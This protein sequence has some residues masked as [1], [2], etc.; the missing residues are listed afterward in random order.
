MPWIYT[1]TCTANGKYYLGRAKNLNARKSQH[2]SSLKGGRHSNPHLQSAYNK[3][4]V[5]AFKFEM[6]YETST[7][8]ECEQRELDARDASDMFNISTRSIGGDVIKTFPPERQAEIYARISRAKKE[9]GKKPPNRIRCVID[10]V[11]YDSYHDASKDLGIPIVTV[12]YRC[13]VSKNVKFKNWHLEGSPKS[14]SDVFNPAEVHCG[15]PMWA[16]GLRFPS[17]SAACRHFGLTS[18]AVKNRCESKNYPNWFRE[19]DKGGP[20]N[21]ERLSRK[22][23]GAKPMGLETQGNSV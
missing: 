19:T 10:G 21:A 5:D 11:T 7:P 17:Q 18:C 20:I 9:L 22:G 8:E 14:D 13:A 15:V 23:V 4:G 2:F 3:Y 1:I 12:R 6:L 16:E